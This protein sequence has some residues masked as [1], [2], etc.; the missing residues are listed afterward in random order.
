MNGTTPAAQRRRRSR[1]A[2][3]KVFFTQSRAGTDRKENLAPTRLTSRQTMK[4]PRRHAPA[5]GCAGE[6]E[7]VGNKTAWR[8]QTT[9]PAVS[10]RS[11]MTDVPPWWRRDKD[12]CAAASTTYCCGTAA[13]DSRRSHDR[14]TG[15][16]IRRRE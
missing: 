12:R 1:D 10:A 15:Q 7:H 2:L 13:T 14:F 4:N 6:I 3:R 11:M 5:L 9:R 16:P 8:T